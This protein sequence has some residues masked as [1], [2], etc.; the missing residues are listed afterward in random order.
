MSDPIGKR[1]RT[2]HGYV[3]V[4]SIYHGP[5]G[6]TVG[7]LGLRWLREDSSTGGIQQWSH[8]RS[9]VQSNSADGASRLVATF[10]SQVI[11]LADTE[12]GVS[13]LTSRVRQVVPADLIS[14]DRT[15]KQKETKNPET[16]VE[17]VGL[18]VGGVVCFS[19]GVLLVRYVQ[20]GGVTFRGFFVPIG[21][22]AGMVGWGLWTMIRAVFR[23]IV[24]K[25]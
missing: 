4:D 5:G 6:I 14:V 22:G 21:V 3:N 16:F 2:C 19:G 20:F 15:V 10:E 13:F 17:G 25:P 12:T 7:T 9:W 18:I 8:L 24:R 1:R 23:G 11:N